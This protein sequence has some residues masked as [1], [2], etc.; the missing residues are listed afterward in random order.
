[1]SVLV[2]LL[3]V[4]VIGTLPVTAMHFSNLEVYCNIFIGNG[5]G[6]QDDFYDKDI[7]TLMLLSVSYEFSELVL[8]PFVKQMRLR[9]GD[10]TQDSLHNRISDLTKRALKDK[11]VQ[12][13]WADLM[14]LP[15]L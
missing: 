5:R 1:M 8:V 12:N 6:C 7:G 14:N 3:L 15:F 9:R 13:D 4:W 2:F 11:K 10:V